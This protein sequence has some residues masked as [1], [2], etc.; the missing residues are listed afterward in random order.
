MTTFEIICSIVTPLLTFA[1]A[2]ISYYFMLKKKIEEVALD[3][4][5]TAEDLDA[6][7]AE[8]F[9]EAV[10]IVQNAI[11]APWKMMFPQ[12][13]IEAVVQMIF[14]KVQEFAKKQV[15]KEA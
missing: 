9:K 1:A 5:N 15:K 8:K 11:P 6:I 4:I 13:V 12:P 3:A 14:D 7:G 2:I 10:A